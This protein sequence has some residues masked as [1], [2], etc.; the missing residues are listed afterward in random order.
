MDLYRTIRDLLDERKRLDALIA[1]M[2]GVQR[3]QALREPQVK[4]RRGRKGMD[5]DQRKEVSERM[6]KYWAGRRV[7]AA[8]KDALCS[9]KD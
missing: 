5:E 7:M 2:E 8:G 6:R 4:K 1:R 3:K 9:D